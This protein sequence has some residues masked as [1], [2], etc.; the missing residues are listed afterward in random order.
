[1]QYA[2]IS[3]PIAALSESP[4]FAELSGRD[5]LP[6]RVWRNPS[7]REFVT[8]LRSST[9]DTAGL[10]GLLTETDLY[11]WQSIN[12]LHIDF[13]RD[14]GLLGVRIALRPTEVQTNDESVA[15]PE[16]FPWIFP[17]R[18]Q[19]EATDIEDRRAIVTTYLQANDRLKRLYVT[20]FHVAWYS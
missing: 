14:T 2:E 3:R 12:L 16:Q 19:A 20:G 10:R 4:H 7:R 17:D 15:L 13:E 9:A 1:M 11:V 6:C 5:G 18:T 8:A